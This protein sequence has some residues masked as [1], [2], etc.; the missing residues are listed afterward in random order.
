MSK[1]YLALKID[2]VSSRRAADRAKLQEQLFRAAETCNARFEDEVAARFL[3]THGDEVQGMLHD[4]GASDLLPIIEAWMDALRPHRLRF[5]VGYGTINTPMQELAIGMDGDAW[6]RA[7]EAVDRADRERRQLHVIGY[8]DELDAALNA[9]GNLLLILRSGWTD[10]QL[11][12]V[13]HAQRAPTQSDAAKQMGVAP[14]T[15]SRHLSS[16]R[17]PEYRDGHEA[18]KL[19]I[20]GLVRPGT[21]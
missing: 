5:G 7:K 14:A 6:H 19:L 17:W 9:L 20:C 8:G 18:F 2:V 4:E 10:R 11:Q 15:F 3:V 13:D 12:A 21:A 16:A 1:R